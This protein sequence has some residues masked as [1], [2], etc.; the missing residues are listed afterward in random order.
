MF[1]SFILIQL[2]R[3]LC[4]QHFMTLTFVPIHSGG[5]YT[6]PLFPL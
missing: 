6:R 3:F 2:N 5:R 1:F 4:S